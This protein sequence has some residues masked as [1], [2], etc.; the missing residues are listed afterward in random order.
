MEDRKIRTLGRR[1][2]ATLLTLGLALGGFSVFAPAANAVKGNNG[3]VKI[4]EAGTPDEDVSN[5]PQINCLEAAW[6]GFDATADVTTFDVTFINP[7]S[8]ATVQH[9]ADQITLDLDAAGGSS[10]FDGKF[11]PAIDTTGVEPQNGKWHIRVDVETTTANGSTSKS[12]TVWITNECST[13]ETPSSSASVEVHKSVSGTAPQGTTFPFDVECTVGDV[14]GGSFSLAAGGSS[15]ATVTWDGESAPS[16][17][18]TETDTGGATSTAYVV[19]DGASTAG[20]AATTDSLEDGST[21]VVTF[22]NT[23]TPRGCQ[24]ECDTIPPVIVDIPTTTVPAPTTTVPAPTTTVAP[25]V[26]P[27]VVPTTV[28]TQVEGVQVVAP[29]PPAQVQ[30]AQLARTGAMTD[31]LIVAAGLCLLLGGVVLTASK[32]RT[33]VPTRRR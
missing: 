30:P 32:E 4:R 14:T 12:K 22:T 15:T 16:C 10:D 1:G 2:G 27:E 33:A 26:E 29:A 18:V 17:T 28:P 23:Y 3:T 7:T 13:D 19:D 11:Q 20:T 24:V 9:F 8:A 21:S 6:Y 31:H 5:D 25:V